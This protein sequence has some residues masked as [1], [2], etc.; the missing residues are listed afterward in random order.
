MRPHRNL[1][2]TGL[3]RGARG[4]DQAVDFVRHRQKAVIRGDRRRIRFGGLDDLAGLTR[5]LFLQRDLQTRGVEVLAQDGGDFG[6]MGMG[7]QP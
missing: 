5:R 7:V 6:G 4:F 3:H 2:V 1:V